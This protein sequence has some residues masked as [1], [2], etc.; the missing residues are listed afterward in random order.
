MPRSPKFSGT[1]SR[2]IRNGTVSTCTVDRRAHPAPPGGSRSR[3]QPSTVSRPGMYNSLP[4]TRSA[5]Y[6]M[7]RL[8]TIIARTVVR[9]AHQGESHEGVYIIDLQTEAVDQVIR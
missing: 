7:E 5:K 4:Y 1:R 6:G 9:S 8:P 2:S 3:S